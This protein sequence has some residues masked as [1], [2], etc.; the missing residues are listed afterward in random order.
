MSVGTIQT[1]VDGT[2]GRWPWFN[3][4]RLGVIILVVITLADD[5]ASKCTHMGGTIYHKEILFINFLPFFMLP[6]FSENGYINALIDV[7]CI[8]WIT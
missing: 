2:N 4:S 6:S 1:G 8:C 5:L 3:D 7:C